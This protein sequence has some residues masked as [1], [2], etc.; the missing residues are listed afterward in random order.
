MVCGIM[1]VGGKKGR[2]L[3]KLRFRLVTNGQTSRSTSRF[4]GSGY[5]DSSPVAHGSRPGL[6]TPGP[7]PK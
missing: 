7:K 4:T 3:E 6:T 2:A 1:E 5:V